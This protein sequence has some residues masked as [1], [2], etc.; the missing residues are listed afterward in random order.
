MLTVKQRRP[1]QVDDH[2]AEARVGL[3]VTCELD[4]EI[5]DDATLKRAVAIELQAHSLPPDSALVNRVDLGQILTE[6]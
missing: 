1:L 5:C 2:L 6:L 3:R 4:E